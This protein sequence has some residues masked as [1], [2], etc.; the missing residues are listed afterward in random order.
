MKH[1]LLL[2]A[3]LAIQAC[4][5][6]RPAMPIPATP[7]AVS[8]PADVGASLYDRL[9]GMTAIR[10]VVDA[11]VGRVVADARINSFF[12]GVDADGL[13]AK[14]SD[15]ICQA[16]GGPCTYQGRTMRD[17]H[18]GMNITDAHFDALVEDL[19]GALNQFSVPARE[20]N[21]LLSALGGMRRDIVGQ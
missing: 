6:G 12:R 10:A 3:A 18:R 17:T 15:Q 14:L 5:S 7:E 11:F 20:R 13:K 9:G 21:E 2:T 19:V 1:A 16:A 4:S 8:V